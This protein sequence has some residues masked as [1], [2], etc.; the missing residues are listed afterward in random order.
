MKKKSRCVPIAA[1]RLET[2]MTLE[3][4]CGFTSLATQVMLHFCRQV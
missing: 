1:S 3:G 2:G 4:L